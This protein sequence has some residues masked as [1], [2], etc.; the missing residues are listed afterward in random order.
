VGD[1]R[2]LF[3]LLSR[4]QRAVA[5]RAD[6]RLIVEHQITSVQAGALLY[7]A[8]NDGCTLGALGEGLGLHG[9]AITGLAARLERL[10]LA[11][12]CADPADGRT[13]RLTL[14]AAGKNKALALGPLVRSFQAEL[15]RG[16]S[17]D[18]LETVLRFLRGLVARYSE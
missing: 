11:T 3:Y 15:G 4:A 7:L 16:L 18:E 10:G 14:S 17:R 2:R 8:R 9:S 5:R 13:F 1:D 12:K 6:A